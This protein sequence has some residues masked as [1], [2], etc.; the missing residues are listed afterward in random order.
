MK[1]TAIT[2]IRI[3]FVLLFLT[4]LSQNANGQLLPTISASSSEASLTNSTYKPILHSSPKHEVRAVWLTTIGGID[5]PHSFANSPQA[6]QRQKQELIDILDRLKKS[7]V[8]TI[9]LQTRIR[10]TTIYPSKF[11]PWDACLSGKPGV[12]PGYDALKFAIDECHQRGMEIHA[13]VVTI[14]IGKWNAAGCASLR[15]S[16]PNLVRKIGQ[17][18]FMNPENAQTANYLADICEEITRNYDV[19]GI[20]LDYI[21]YPETWKIKVNRSQGRQYITNIVSA[22]NRR[23]KA[24]KPWVKISCSPIGKFDDL[25]RYRSNGWNAYTAV[26]QDAQG[27]L[28]TGLMDELF[29]MMY[30]KG[31]QFFPFALDWAEHAYGRIVA[32]GLGIYFLNPREGNWTLETITREMEVLRQNG[33]GHTYFRSKF[34]TD[35]DKGIYDFALRFDRHPALVPPMTWQH[36]TP[37]ASPSQLVVLPNAISWTPSNPD[38]QQ[39]APDILYNVYASRTFPVDIND[40]QNLVA[41]RLIAPQLSFSHTTQGRFFAVTA[42]DRY[43]N[44]SLPLQSHGQKQEIV[45]PQNVKMLPCD[46]KRVEMPQRDSAL[47]AD[48]ISIEDLKG[49]IVATRPYRGKTTDISQLADGMY[50]MRSVNRKGVSHRLGLFIIKR[51]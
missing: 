51:K 31:N 38:T 49:R 2:Y 25:A 16:H 43:G 19:D 10:A 26:C 28:R 3:A 35:N 45:I 20:H 32:P 21:R 27:W 44:E 18:G 42:M 23:V 12:S 48:I 30:F 5:W 17:D 33:L 24:L 36:A 40:A 9:L 34:F 13:W 6:I 11:E 37:P 14:P 15:K 22:I 29:P 8:N 50:V 4:I 39:P 47:D 1:Q 7:G 46:G 41:T